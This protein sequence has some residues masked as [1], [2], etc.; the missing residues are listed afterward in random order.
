[1]SPTQRFLWLL[2]P[3]PIGL[4]TF[5]IIHSSVQQSSPAGN[6]IVPR[7]G[8]KAKRPALQ[9]Q[10]AKRA[11]L[12]VPKISKPPTIDGKMDPGEWD[13][14]AVVTG[15]MNATGVDA[16]LIDKPNAKI[17]LAHDGKNFY[18]AVYCELLP[19]EVPSRKY[20]KRDEPVYLDSYQLELWLTPPAKGQVVTYQMIGN[21]YGAIYD[22]R[23]VPA[24]GNIVTG[25]NGRYTLKNTFERGKYWIAELSVPFADFGVERVSPDQEW[26]GLVGVAW[27]QHSWPY[28]GGWYKN[29]E[30]HAVLTFADDGECVRLEDM[31]SLFDNKLAPK[32][33]ILNAAEKDADYTVAVQIGKEQ[34]E[35]KVR[36]KARSGAPLV[37]QKD[38]PAAKEP[39]ICTLK[40]T[41]PDGWTLLAGDWR[42]RP[43]DFSKNPPPKAPQQE[44]PFAA[45]VLFAPQALG[46]KLWADVLDYPRRAELA[47]VR[48]SVHPEKQ[49][50]PVLTKDFSEFAYDAADAYVWLPK[51]LPYGKYEVRTRF[52]AKDGAVLDERVH[53]FEYQDL[54]KQFYWWGNK[55]GT[56]RTVIPPFTP[57]KAA[58]KTV[59]VWGRDYRM[60]GALPAQV[61]SQKAEMLA[62]PI[63]LMAVAG[64]KSVPAQITKPFRMGKSDAVRMEFQG[65]YEVAG[66]TLDLTGYVEYDGM[67][68]YTLRGVPRA[69]VKL[70]RLY[71]SV[72]VKPAHA[73]TY[74]ST[75][76]GWS[77]AYDFV[78]EQSSAKPFWT[79]AGLADFVPY[80]GLGDDDR[81]LQ[82]F[83]DNDH[84][85]VVGQ[86]APCAELYRRPDAVELRVNLVRRS[87]ALT[88][89]FAAKFGLIATPIKPLPS[90]WRHAC[91]HFAPI[92]DSKINFFYGPGH[93]ACPIDPDDTAK[94]AQVLGVNVSGKN[95]D[96]VLARLKPHSRIPSLKTLQ[97]LNENFA[98]SAY[99]ELTGKP[100]A[101]RRCYF[102]NANMY[103]EGYRSKAFDTLFPGEWTLEPSS[104]WFHLTTIDSYRDFFTFYMDL[105]MKHWAMPG[106][107]FDE[108]YLPVDYNVFNGNGKIMPD[109]SVRGSVPLMHQREFLNRM[110]QIFAD[111]GRT[112]FLWVHE[113]NYMA[114]YAISAADI[115]MFG[116]DRAPTAASDVMATISPA[117][118]RSIGRAQKFGFIPVWM[119]QAGRGG[120]PRSGFHA[121]Q[122]FGWAWLH[123]VVPEY[124][125]STRGHALVAVRQRWGIDKDDVSF[126][127]YWNNTAVKT[128]DPQF[129]ASAWTRRGGKLLVEVM[130]LHKDDKTTVHL[131]LDAKALGL[132]A[133]FKVYDVE[134]GPMLGRYTADMREADR[135]LREDPAGN[136]KRAAQLVDAHREP[137]AKVTYDPKLWQ[138]VG[139]GPQVRLSVPSRD[140]VTLIV[141]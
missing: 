106:M 59:S 109:G 124:H 128:D 36:V 45:R 7:R 17:Y 37:L 119:N 13:T 9:A 76:G 15:F 75:A 24:L 103:F 97:N 39:R 87:G 129:L 123:D 102:F 21:A 94:L 52:L 85:W 43:K 34:F 5:F 115:A 99:A 64:A 74:Y 62:G 65:Q 38:L 33:T 110:R 60:E 108:C 26:G 42:F 47:K 73:T 19:G 141:E 56:K 11:R 25:W 140:F 66:V 104:S 61:V 100:E 80:V 121:R 139:A 113:S 125:T 53:P 78:P 35:E 40:V 67:I 14:A 91:L 18:M 133:G 30:Q 93:G 77:A 70:E 12:T 107:Y 105:W 83:A 29:I 90:S 32:L 92:A 89:P 16:G 114:P 68:Y 126:I 8:A 138:Q 4:L 1:M 58:D 28:T 117:L 48:F 96:E 101:V 55:L 111:N 69:G 88:K 122:L 86:D 49:E 6:L 112:P 130:N 137:D 46:L 131:T 41:A 79:S 120:G 10:A 118:L 116:E 134:Q 44:L 50:K 127:P 71:V 95:P 136:E 20:R 2:L 22:C 98:G 82:W 51:D 57:V 63:T 27:P 84:D 54:A 132:K 31:T 81:A 72:P 23:Q 135:L 3:I